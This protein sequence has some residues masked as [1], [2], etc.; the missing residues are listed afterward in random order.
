VRSV[1]VDRD[2]TL[3]ALCYVKAPIL[4]VSGKEDTILPS[5][6]SRRIAEMLPRARHVKVEGVAHLV[7]LEA[8]EA[9]NKLILYFVA[10]LPQV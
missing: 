6:Y 7:P 8:P 3:D 9:A 1:L 4:V 10:D 5:H 2:S